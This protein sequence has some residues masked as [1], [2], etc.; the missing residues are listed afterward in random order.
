MFRTQVF[1][2]ADQLFE[3]GLYEEV[4]NILKP[5]VPRVLGSKPSSG[6][7]RSK[8]LRH[9]LMS[10][11]HLSD[12]ASIIK[13]AGNIIE[14]ILEGV[15]HCEVRLSV[16]VFHLFVKTVDGNRVMRWM[17]RKF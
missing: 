8:Q 1:Q 14:E 16:C 2:N 11:Q 3:E 9:L 17:F 13:V 5:T 12:H 10:F 15:K 7:H 6:S 4:V